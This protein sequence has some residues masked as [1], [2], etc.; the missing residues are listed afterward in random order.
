MNEHAAKD[1]ASYDLYRPP[2]RLASGDAGAGAAQAGFAEQVYCLTLWADAND[3]TQVML[4][5]ASGSKAVSMAFSVKELPFFTLWKNSAENNC[6]L[7][8]ADCRL[9]TEDLSAGR[10]DRKPKIGNPRLGPRQSR[11]FTIDFALHADREQ[12]FAAGQEVARIWAGRPTQVDTSPLA[13]EVET[14]KKLN[15]SDIIKAARTWRPGY[16][17]WYGKPAPDFA[18]TDL[19]GK[20]H[21]LS[22]YKGKNVLIIFWATWCG[23]CRVE[24]PHLIEL[25]K[26]ISED[27]LA[28]LAISN[29]SPALVKSFVAKAKMNYTILMD[30]GS[31]PGPYNTISA[32]PSGFFIDRQ[33]K[34]K[35]AT[36]GLVSLD[37][38]KAVF[39][40]E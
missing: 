11:S 33:G 21:K 3:R 23:P 40:A 18:L 22:D 37:E 28:M 1:V 25:R 39:D 16:Q 26:T 5:N 30:Q 7:S 27:D 2:P 20:E 34:I 31:L 17:A 10:R 36:T 9:E 12:V 32:I 24:I 15:L 38:I 4:R 35:L 8:I 19:A 14:A 6:R 29:E 13:T